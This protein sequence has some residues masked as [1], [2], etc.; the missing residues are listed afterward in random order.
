MTDTSDKAIQRLMGMRLGWLVRSG[1]APLALAG[2]DDAPAPPTTVVV[3]TPP[4]D[5]GL[6]VLL[7]VM[8]GVAFLAVVAALVFAWS[9]A[10]ERRTR[11]DAEAALREAEDTV[12][13]LTGHPVARLRL[14]L[15]QRRPACPTEPETGRGDAVARWSQ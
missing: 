2:C 13:A 12:L 1:V 5:G 14:S 6:S 15:D 7:T 11:R 9:W 10:S 3:N 4:T 8:I